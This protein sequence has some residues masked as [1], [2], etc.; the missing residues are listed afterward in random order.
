MIGL[1][2]SPTLK[3]AMLI[4][5]FGRFGGAERMAIVHAIGLAK[6]DHDVTLYTDMFLMDSAWLSM[7]APRVEV[8]RLP[9][10][11][12]GGN[13]VRELNNFDKLII[14]HHVEPLVAMRIIRKYSDKTY[15]YTGEVLRAIWEDWITG[16]DY[17]KFSPTVF[18]TARHFY[19]GLSRLA[20]TGPMY[21]LTMSFL[22][23][24]D[25]ATVR[26]YKAIIANSQYM[27]GLVQNVYRYPGPMFVA[28]P[29]SS[30]PGSMF[31]PDYGNGEYVLAVGALLPNKNHHVLL[32]AMSLLKEP[33]T[34]RI[35]GDGQEKNRLKNQARRLGI[36]TRF[37]SHVTGEALCRFY[38]G[39]LFVVVPS[40]SEP[41]G[42]TALEAALAGKPAI[43][44]DLGGTKEFV[45][46][47]QTGFVVNPRRAEALVS[48]METL[49]YDKGLRVRMGQ[50]A[51]ERAVHSFTPE[52]SA[53]A[54]TRALNP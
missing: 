36:D 21:N 27:A 6:A 35:I 17:R 50:K 15:W 46:D 12:K 2:F 30:L 5:P 51:R 53:L 26:R 19:G 34:L 23:F 43:V 37:D 49:L 24:L 10:G 18:T 38:E 16:E 20:L 45:L 28:Y 41:F 54:L 4:H 52:N 13:V 11:L 3:L 42:M 1:R 25:L 40:L 9:Y 8:R 47:Q 14:H 7:L 32:E 39:S 29:T 44:T 31:R 33:P 48:A 22:R